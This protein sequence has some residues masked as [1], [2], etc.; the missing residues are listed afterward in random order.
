MLNESLLQNNASTA[1]ALLF[2]ML[3]KLELT[4]SSI[5]AASSEI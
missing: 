2:L 3:E 4:V 5:H 1:S